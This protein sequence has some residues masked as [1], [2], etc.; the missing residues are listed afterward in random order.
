MPQRIQLRR[1]KGWRLPAQT[2]VVARPTRW[3]N[4][5]R[6]GVDGDAAACVRQ[7]HAWLI[8]NGEQGREPSPATV[9]AQLAGRDLACW[10]APD[11]PCHGDVLLEL[12]NR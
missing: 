3:G 12:A 5:F 2:V 11:Q 8:A 7:Y 9:R 10:C 4:P 1:S 6:L